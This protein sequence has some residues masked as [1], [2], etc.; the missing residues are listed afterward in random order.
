MQRRTRTL[1]IALACAAVLTGCSGQQRVTSLKVG[2]CF[3]DTAQMVGGGEVSR[4]PSVPCNQPHD[5]EVYHVARY[6]G[7]SYSRADISAFADRVCYGAFAPYVGRSY[8]SS[9]IDFTWFIPTP[10]SWSRGDRE[11]VCVAYHMNL[12]K[13]RRSVRGS[14]L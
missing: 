3:D 2:D 5:N 10:E 12:D 6:S 9:V 11:V 1:V 4:V 13:L 7:S 14:G 8:E